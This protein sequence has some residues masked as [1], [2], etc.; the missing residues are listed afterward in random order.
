MSKRFRDTELWGRE[1]YRRLT[2]EQK[3]AWG[4]LLDRC[5]NV[6]VI[7]LDRGTADFLI[8][9]TVDWDEIVVSC[10]N[11]IEVLPDGK[12]W[13]KDFC[14]FQYGELDEKC[15]P[16][17]SYIRLL[18]K[19][20]LEVIFKGMVTLK[21]KEKDLDKEKE[22]DKSA[23]PKVAYAE[24]VRMTKAEYSALVFKYDERTVKL[25]IEKVAAQQIKT[26]KS[27]KSPRGA[28]LQWGLRAALEE[29]KKTPM[30]RTAKPNPACPECG[31]EL[32]RDFGYWT[33]KTH[34]RREDVE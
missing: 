16:H 2:P 33:C 21:E 14:D 12:W 20:G 3:C 30:S 27:Y 13:V 17:A 34:G 10:N 6:G 29:L 24:G 28:I 25:A 8:G 18:R 22:K 1:W 26:G 4:Y 15:K 32:E 31:V 11:N 23:E 5:D 9:T 7:A 19:H